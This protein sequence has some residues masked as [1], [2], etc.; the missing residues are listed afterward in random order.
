MTENNSFSSEHAL[1]GIDLDAIRR[2]MLRGSISL[3]IDSIVT[4]TPVNRCMLMAKALH[5]AGSSSSEMQH[6][7]DHSSIMHG[8]RQEAMARKT[9]DGSGKA[10]PAL[11]APAQVNASKE[12]AC[13]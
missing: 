9:N 6:I 8:L 12:R 5:A 11:Y 4:A 7:I 10:L 2:C 1:T 13:V 3:E